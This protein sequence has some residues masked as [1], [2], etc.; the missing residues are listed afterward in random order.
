MAFTITCRHFK[1]HRALL[2]YAESSAAD[3][4]KLMAK[5]VHRIQNLRAGKAMF[6]MNRTVFQML[7]IER[8]SDVSS[9]GGLTYL[10][11]DGQ[12]IPH[13]RGIHIRTVDAL[14]ETEARVV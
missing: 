4:Q 12:A 6:Y 2:E 10:N 14:V 1:P 7:D 13:F 9:G 3:L 8:R 11:V 5:A